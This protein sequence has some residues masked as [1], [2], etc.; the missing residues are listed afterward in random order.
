ML[1]SA[2]AS[3]QTR[4]TLSW[5][6]KGSCRARLMADVLSSP[7]GTRVAAAY[8]FLQHQGANAGISW[9][10]LHHHLLHPATVNG[11]FVHRKQKCIPGP[12]C[13]RVRPQLRSR[14]NVVSCTTAVGV[15]CTSKNA[16]PGHRGAYSRF[17]AYSNRIDSNRSQVTL[18]HAS[19]Y[20]ST[21]GAYSYGPCS[22]AMCCERHGCTDRPEESGQG[23]LLPPTR[24]HQVAF[25]TAWSVAGDSYGSKVCCPT[26]RW[27]GDS[28]HGGPG[29]FAPSTRLCA[30]PPQRDD[31]R[32]A[33]PRS[34]RNAH[35]VLRSSWLKDATNGWG[36]APNARRA[37]AAAPRFAG[38]GAVMA[39][40]R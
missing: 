34:Q 18:C 40:R 19:T 10:G 4:G 12:V 20:H 11:S 33:A 37:P 5:R 17:P 32:T 25:M 9:L 28:L 13:Q 29:D 24:S 26:P 39:R 3:T 38:A 23:V 30:V 1:A 36:G 15:P 22:L 7:Q 8:A 21:L 2:T 6:L 31:V 35:E 14:S 27:Q 16:S